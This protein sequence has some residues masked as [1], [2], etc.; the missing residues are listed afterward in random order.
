MP[1]QKKVRRTC[2]L[3]PDVDAFLMEFSKHVGVSETIRAA[4]NFYQSKLELEKTGK[5]IV[6]V[7]KDKTIWLKRKASK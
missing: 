5:K 4:L 6:F 2:Y 1:R 7:D 3:T